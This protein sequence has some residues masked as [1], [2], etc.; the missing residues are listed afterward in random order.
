MTLLVTGGAGFIGSNF[1][2]YWM[3]HYPEDRV[4][5]VD[6]L[7]YA[8]NIAAL[9]PMMDRPNFRFCHLDICDRDGIERLFEDERPD[10]VVNF[11]AESHVDRSIDLQFIHIQELMRLLVKK[12]ILWDTGP[13][14]VIM[15]K[16]ILSWMSRNMGLRQEKIMCIF[17][18]RADCIRLDITMLFLLR[19]S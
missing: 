10:I 9:Q 7:T 16:I 19:M 18:T 2:F 8:G 11:A 17:R 14:Y 5:C 4:I 1:I 15:T 3:K 13:P 12:R 6:K